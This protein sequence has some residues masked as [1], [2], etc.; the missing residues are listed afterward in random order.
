[1]LYF[2]WIGLRD[3]FEATE[4]KYNLLLKL[5]HYLF[6]QSKIQRICHDFLESVVHCCVLDRS[7]WIVVFRANFG[8]WTVI[9]SWCGSAVESMG[10]A[11]VIVM[12]PEVKKVWCTHVAVYVLNTSR[13][14]HYI[15]QHRLGYLRVR[16]ITW[17]S[18]F[19]KTFAQISI[20]SLVVSS[21]SLPSSSLLSS[22]ES[23]HYLFAK[24][25]Q[26]LMSEWWWC[27]E[28]FTEGI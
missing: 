26:M 14:L 9:T 6:K 7:W 23:D 15:T 3:K 22:T 18:K 13:D 21:S 24:W 16:S 5:I 2:W 27:G 28:R 8:S 1:M 17:V 20:N 12:T 25:C 4:V 11:A 19:E 10:F